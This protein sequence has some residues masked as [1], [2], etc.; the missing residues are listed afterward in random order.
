MDI[1]APKPFSSE[2]LNCG[3][4]FDYDGKTKQAAA[5]EARM[6]AADFGIIR[7]RPVRRWRN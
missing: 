3:I 5:I 4:V 6:A 7:K 2:S 1:T